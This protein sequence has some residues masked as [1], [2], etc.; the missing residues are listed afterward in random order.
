MPLQEQRANPHDSPVQTTS[1]LP[2]PSSVA[3]SMSSSCT[4]AS[5]ELSA[6]LGMPRQ[7]VCEIS[8]GKWKL[9]VWIPE[10]AQGP[11]E[12]HR[13][14]GKLT[15]NAIRQLSVNAKTSD[16]SVDANLLLRST[17]ARASVVI[18]VPP[19]TVRDGDA[20]SEKDD[21]GKDGDDDQEDEELVD[22]EEICTID[23]VLRF[24]TR[25]VLFPLVFSY[26]ITQMTESSDS[27][28][29]RDEKEKTVDESLPPERYSLDWLER[30]FNKLAIDDKIKFAKI[31]AQAQADGWPTLQGACAA[32]YD[33]A[34]GVRNMERA[35]NYKTKALKLG[36]IRP[37]LLLVSM[38]PGRRAAWA[39]S[40][41]INIVR[42]SRFGD[43]HWEAYTILAHKR[44][45]IVARAR[46]TFREK[47]NPL[48]RSL[49]WYQLL[50]RVLFGIM[51]TRRASP[52]RLLQREQMDQELLRELKDAK[53]SKTVSAE[54][55]QVQTLSAGPASLENLFAQQVFAARSDTIFPG[56]TFH[57]PATSSESCQSDH[58]EEEETGARSDEG[59]SERLGNMTNCS[60]SAADAEDGA[61][62]SAQD[63][64]RDEFRKLAVEIVASSSE[65]SAKAA[66]LRKH[67]FVD[68]AHIAI[69][70][71]SAYKR[72]ALPVAFH[73]TDA[74]SFAQESANASSEETENE[75]SRHME[76]PGVSWNAQ[77]G[78]QADLFEQEFRDI[79]RIKMKQENNTLNITTVAGVAVPLILSSLAI[80]PA[81]VAAVFIARAAVKR[82][83]KDMPASLAAILSGLILQRL[84]LAMDDVALEPYYHDENLDL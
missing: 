14:M 45:G 21:L 65:L 31:V 55:S 66:R 37:F 46:H 72:A 40:L 54:W 53:V 34:M 76:T 64:S 3:S 7:V 38:H 9:D 32:T 44:N 24:E 78:S 18:D 67:G 47:V 60:K 51:S 79:V 41:D 69:A 83:C 56:G 20:S 1:L 36:L 11:L 19:K 8:P 84:W 82:V 42:C 81:P 28:M 30:R 80:T 49:D 35:S 75:T 27:L 50:H 17:R 12:N 39:L 71:L 48:S 16:G 29:T 61:S 68:E 62:R 6:R 73:G 2:Y 63:L 4:F 22:G 59:S 43:P 58:I 70:V 13:V 57:I 33:N 25:A 52:L 10:G 5:P 74:T 15:G 23:L 26:Q 77:W